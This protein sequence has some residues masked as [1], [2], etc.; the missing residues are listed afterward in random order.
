MQSPQMGYKVALQKFE[1]R[2][3]ENSPMVARVNRFKSSDRKGFFNG[4]NSNSEANDNTTNLSSNGNSG[5]LE[6]TLDI[7]GKAD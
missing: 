4:G 2:M 5:K 6:N 1:S 7:S 3:K